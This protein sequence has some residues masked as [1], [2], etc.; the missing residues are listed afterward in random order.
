[1]TG[2]AVNDLVLGG[3][4]EADFADSPT[5]AAVL[6]GVEGDFELEL[7]F[8]HRMRTRLAG[9]HWILLTAPEDVFEAARLFDSV[10]PE[11][12]ESLPTSRVLRAKIA[13]AFARRRAESLAARRSRQRIADR[14]S[15]WFGRVEVPGLLRALDPS[16]GALPLMVRGVPGSGRALLARYAELFRAGAT[17]ATLRIHAS[18]VDDAGDLARRLDLL[19]RERCDD[20]P[21]FWIDEVDSLSVSA[22]IAL[23][24]WITHESP[25]LEFEVPGARWMATAGPSRW[26]DPLEPALERAF[27]PLVLEIPALHGEPDAVAAFATEMAR[28][29]TRS[30]GGPVRR[31]SAGALAELTAYPWQGDRSEVEAVLRASFAETNRDPIEAEDLQLDATPVQEIIPRVQGHAIQQAAPDSTSETDFASVDVPIVEV[32]A[33]E[34]DGALEDVR[35]AELEPANSVSIAESKG[36]SDSELDESVRL[37]EA[38]FEIADSEEVSEMAER[39]EADAKAGDPSWRRLARSLSHEI[40]NPLVSIRTFAELLPEHYDDATFRARFSDLVGR[41]IDHISDVVTRMQNVAEQDETATEATDVSA[42][43]EDLL[44]E[45]REQIAQRRLLVLRE[46]ER[47]APLAWA[48]PVALRVAL[49]GLIDRALDSLPERGDLFV[50]TR[51]VD[52]GQG[53]APRLRILLRH[54]N[55]DAQGGGTQP[56]ELSPEANVLEYVLAETV[57]RACGGSLTID[58][59]GAQESL[60]LVELRTPN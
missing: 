47:D 28:D 40:R 43:L 45:R 50:A 36:A 30:V 25:P 57:A 29:W 52:P 19:A 51:H 56:G 39:I 24:G 8:V 10:Q 33:D 3:P 59:S 23:A 55:P 58:S 54:H 49:A 32:I 38:S 1:M 53:R 34:D 44:E 7:E 18:D 6:L 2:R 17:G 26:Q 37:S 48:E 22:Q 20:A 16:L 12:L 5:P 35:E 31:L 42:M 11:V 15:A 14:F 13:S 60:I 27:T 41:D 9:S 46:L 21:T 4:R